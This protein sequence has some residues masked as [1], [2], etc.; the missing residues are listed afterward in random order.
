[1]IDEN[2]KNELISKF[3]T[4]LFETNGVDINELD[5][6]I[7]D[8]EI[9]IMFAMNNSEMVNLVNTNPIDKEKVT[10]LFIANVNLYKLAKKRKVTVHGS[11]FLMSIATLIGYDSSK[12]YGELTVGMHNSVFKRK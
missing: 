11:S 10:K 1:M 5:D 3:R 12:L 8:D 9:K 6:L 4:E 7:T 2:Y